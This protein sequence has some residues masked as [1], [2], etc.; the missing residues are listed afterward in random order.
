MVFD[1]PEPGK[2]LETGP[3]E[4]G[5][6]KAAARGWG[7]ALWRWWRLS[8]TPTT[9]PEA[10][11]ASKAAT[12][13]RWGRFTSQLNEERKREILD[14][15]RSFTYDRYTSLGKRRLDGVCQ[16][17]MPEASAREAHAKKE[18]EDGTMPGDSWRH[19][20]RSS[21]ITSTNPVL[22]TSNSWSKLQRCIVRLQ[23]SMLL[24]S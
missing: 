20:G 10:W 5:G 18:L 14:E 1:H 4:N 12:T 7:R 6:Q 23:A 3:G 16:F 19:W 11:L 24:F 9:N 8:T 22:E 21:A 15:I 17:H 2:P 13:G